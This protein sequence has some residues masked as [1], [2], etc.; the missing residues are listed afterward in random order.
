VLIFRRVLA[1]FFLAVTLPYLLAPVYR[2]PPPQQF[3]GAALWNPY[4]HT[5]ATWH[6]ANLHAHGR[7]WGGLTNGSQLD[8]DVVR[9]Y[10]QHGYSVAGVSDYHWIA[11]QHGIDTLPL[12]EHGY[13]IAKNHQLAIGAHSVEWLDFPLWQGRDQKQ[14]IIDRVGAAADLVAI[15]HPNTAY[16]EDDLRD[17]TGYQLMEVVN[18]PFPGEDFWDV[19]LSTGHLVWALAND[20]SHDIKNARRTFIA[21]NM[22]DAPSASTPDIVDALRRGRHYAVSLVGDK[23]DASL[24]SIEL[25]DTTVTVSSSGVPA[26]YLFVGQDGTVRKTA[27]QVMQASY[28]IEPRDTYIRTVIRTPNIVMYLN[29]IVRYDGAGPPSRRATPN[30]AFT[31]LQRGILAGLCAAVVLLLWRRPSP[32]SP[33]A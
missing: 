22:I 8:E 13:N 2:F 20:D 18:G 33:N 12:Y 21:W 16:S 14:Y 27:D 7:S 10:R 31:W 11:A 4:A 25:Q 15:N 30:F 29:P 1:T 6:R 26:T 5:S 9:A 24:K 32:A 17:L 3:T 23:A 19:A 28:T